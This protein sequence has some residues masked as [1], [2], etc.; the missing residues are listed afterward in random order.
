MFTFTSNWSSPSVCNYVWR[1]TTT[2]F[3]SH[4]PY[5]SN[6]EIITEE[7]LKDGIINLRKYEDP[8]H[9]F[10]SWTVSFIT[11]LI[12]FPTIIGII[13]ETVFSLPILGPALIFIV[14][15]AFP[16]LFLKS[17]D[18]V[19]EHIQPAMLTEAENRLQKMQLLH[20]QHEMN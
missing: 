2:S 8:Y 9:H 14:L 13:P 16:F 11:A 17:V 19:Y 12:I 7:V 18:L 10:K 6:N 20:K 15:I 5:I 3:L 1:N 4:E